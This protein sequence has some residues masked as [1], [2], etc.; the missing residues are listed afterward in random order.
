MLAGEI[1][2]TLG[3]ASEA[4]SKERKP[5]V[6]MDIRTMRSILAYTIIIAGAEHATGRD[7][8]IIFCAR[9]GAAKGFIKGIHS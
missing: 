2:V 3:A 8:D 1:P 9:N 6:P 4:H 5:I 7:D